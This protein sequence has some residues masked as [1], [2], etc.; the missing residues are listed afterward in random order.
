MIEDNM[1]VS[2]DYE[3][4]DDNGNIIDGSSGTE[5]LVYL[6]GSSSILPALEKALTGK[7]AGE[8]FSVSISPDDAYGQRNDN[9]VQI[10]D[11]SVFQDVDELKEGMIF[12]AQQ[13]EGELQVSIVGIDGDEITLDGNHPLAGLTLNFEGVIRDVRDATPEEIEEGAIIVLP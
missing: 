7:N 11:R 1:V 13:P 5:P 8:T 6:H 3:V 2:F 9:L 12:N 4:K 10:V